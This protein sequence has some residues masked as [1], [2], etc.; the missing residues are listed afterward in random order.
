[1]YTPSHNVSCW[2]WWHHHPWPPS[3]GFPMGLILSNDIQWTSCFFKCRRRP[4]YQWQKNNIMFHSLY[5]LCCFSLF[6][7]KPT[8]ICSLFHRIRCFLLLISH[9]NGP[10][11]QIHLTK[12]GFQVSYVQNPIHEYNQPNIDIINENHTTGRVKQIF[13]SI[14]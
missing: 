4:I 7:Q 9:Q 5:F 6:L 3:R 11:A 12:L 8:S 1:M 2:P 10:M 14:N 13:V